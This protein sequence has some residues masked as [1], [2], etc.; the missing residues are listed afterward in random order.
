MGGTC[1][2]CDSGAKAKTWPRGASG[3]WRAFQIFVLQNSSWSANW[4]ACG[5]SWQHRDRTVHAE[6]L[7]APSTLM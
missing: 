7:Q 5:H 3:R 1:W 2:F 4:G 6:P